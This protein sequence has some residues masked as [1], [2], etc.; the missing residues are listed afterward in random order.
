[1]LQFWQ[2]VSSVRCLS[3]CEKEQQTEADVRPSR[4]IGSFGFQTSPKAIGAHTS[5]KKDNDM[6]SLTSESTWEGGRSASKSSSTAQD[7]ECAFL[8]EL[9]ASLD[10]RLFLPEDD[11]STPVDQCLASASRIKFD[12]LRRTEVSEGR[13]VKIE[14]WAHD[15]VKRFRFTHRPFGMTFD[16]RR[17]L[18]A[19][20]GV[21]AFGQAEEIGVEANWTLF[22][23]N[24]KTLEH[25]SF[26]DICALLREVAAPLPQY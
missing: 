4:L 12:A 5:L 11:W 19:V 22:T 7:D 18:V 14:F 17:Q 26:D 9:V 8:G 24:G 16:Q 21:V 23:V 20:R 10:D 13:S 3:C 15:D 2:Y 6:M 1:M 25:L